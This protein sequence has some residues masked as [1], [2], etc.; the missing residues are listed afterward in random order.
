[1]RCIRR[2]PGGPVRRCGKPEP[3]RM[4][5]RVRLPQSLPMTGVAGRQARPATRSLDD[6]RFQRAQLGVAMST[7]CRARPM[8]KRAGE[9]FQHR[10]EH[11][12]GPAGPTETVSQEKSPRPDGRRRHA[13]P[14]PRPGPSSVPVRHGD[15][16]PPNAG[17][18]IAHCGAK[19][20]QIRHGYHRPQETRPQREGGTSDL[21]RF[22]TKASC[23]PGSRA[24]AAQCAAL[25]G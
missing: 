11:L 14:R 1:M 16:C 25:E 10:R 23:G 22:L 9:S 19:K 17:R 8:G 3:W 2:A 21:A 4:S 5:Y 15:P 6:F 7:L 12:N 13:C 24:S 18:V 20:L